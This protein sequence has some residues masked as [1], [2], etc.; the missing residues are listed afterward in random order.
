MIGTEHWCGSTWDTPVSGLAWVEF[1]GGSPLK[2]CPFFAH[3][4]ELEARR[5]LEWNSVL[6]LRI[7]TMSYV[8]DSVF[9]KTK[10]Y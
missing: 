5:L 6:G 4:S 3:R 7:N 1:A 8:Y 2:S 10:Q 9:R